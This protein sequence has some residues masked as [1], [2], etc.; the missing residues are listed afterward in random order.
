[1]QAY[2]PAANSSN[3]ARPF[4]AKRV[5]HKRPAVPGR[6][7]KIGWRALTNA[8]CEALLVLSP[9][10]GSQFADNRGGKRHGAKAMFCLRRFEAQAGLCLL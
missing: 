4:T 5:G 3:S 8:E 6:E 7:H 10:M 2:L 1:V 9:P